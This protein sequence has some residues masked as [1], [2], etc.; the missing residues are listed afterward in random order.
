VFAIFDANKVRAQVHQHHQSQAQHRPPGAVRQA[1][2][3]EKV[4][5]QPADIQN[6]R[7]VQGEGEHGLRVLL[8]EAVQADYCGSD[9]D[10]YQR[11]VH[12]SKT[13]EKTQDHQ[14]Q[15]APQQ[16]RKR[17]KIAHGF[18]QTPILPGSQ[19]QSGQNEHGINSA[20]QVRN[21]KHERHKN[22]RGFKTGP[23]HYLELNPPKRRFLRLY[24]RSISLNTSSLK[25]GQYVLGNTHSA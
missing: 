12:Q 3:R 15:H 11:Q 23:E 24:S 4:S 21:S 2:Q 1:P 18:K 7:N 25:S 9:Q 22:Q 8:L 10:Y 16:E 17:D 6:A 13:A 5:P 19:P 14:G 20:A